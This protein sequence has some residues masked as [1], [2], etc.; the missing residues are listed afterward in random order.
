MQKPPLIGQFCE[1]CFSSLNF[2]GEGHQEGHI[3]GAWFM[4]SPVQEKPYFYKL[5]ENILYG[6]LLEIIREK[7]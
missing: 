7:L 2:P 5:L 4:L 3:S 1:N 6:Y